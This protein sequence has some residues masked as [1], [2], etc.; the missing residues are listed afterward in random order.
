MF[1]ARE[2]IK[3]T[4]GQQVSGKKNT[5]FATVSIDSRTVRNHSLFIPL[6]G[7]NHDAH[8]FISDAFAQGASGVIVSKNMD[9][10]PA[11]KTII[12]VADTL[13][14]LQAIAALNR[15]KHRPKVVGITGSSGKTTTKDMLAAILSEE[16][17]TIKT[18]ENFNNEIGVPLTLLEI[19]AKHKFAAVEMAMRGI[20]EIRDL[21]MIA[22]PDV[23]VITNI[24]K[25]HIAHLKS[26]EQIA[27]A[28]SEIFEG[29]KAPGIAVLPADDDFFALLKT[30]AGKHRIITFGMRDSADVYPVNIKTQKNRLSFKLC[31]KFDSFPINLPL[32]GTH[33]ILN[34]LAAAA[35]AFALDIK[36][37]SIQLGLRRF[38]PSSK[39]ME[40][41]YLRN[42]AMLINDSY[43]ANPDSM[44]AAIEM[45]YQMQNLESKKPSRKIAVL[46]DMLE[47]GLRSISSHQKVGKAV[48]EFEID[49]LVTVG[50]WSTYVAQSAIVN[51]FATQHI[52]S[53]LK[54]QEVIAFLKSIIGPSDVILIKGS[55]GMKMEEIVE[56][57]SQ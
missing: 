27:R 6:I 54:N 35:A 15:K 4:H 57:L 22:R 17:S 49:M 8:D 47:L 12:K 50:K 48:K 44:R 30:K 46:G 16:D 21:T 1:T 52:Y 20:G 26:E 42:Q 10:L 55:R 56:A 53:F 34:A 3:A 18:T 19:K 51:G 29:L 39:R 11:D 31:S 23:A 13:K 41:F 37:A 2:I 24:G 43:N 14:A 5:R 38:K 45:L 40:V 33:N 25:T 7:V 28:K 36:P 9:H 32:P